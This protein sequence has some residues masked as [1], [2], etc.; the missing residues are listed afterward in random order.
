MSGPKPCPALP[1]G[2]IVPAIHTFWPVS[3]RASWAM[4]TPARLISS[5]RSAIPYAASR[6][7]LAPNVLVARSS[8]P[9]L[10][11]AK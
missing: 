3:L 7:T 8:E 4:T 5:I 11:Y 1:A 6:T 9:A 2:P 10:R